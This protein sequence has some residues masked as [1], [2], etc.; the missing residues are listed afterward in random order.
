MSDYP[1][2]TEMGIQN[3]QQIV[4]Y[5]INSM[6]RIDTLR[7]TYKREKGSL[8]PTS[9]SF[10]FPRIQ[11]TPEPDKIA[12]TVLATSP[13]LKEIRRELESLLKLREKTDCTVKTVKKQI[14]ALEN[15]FDMRL[16]EIR[17]MLDE[18]NDAT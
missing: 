5:A 10:E 14:E 9:K 15:E 8:L 11:Q 12:G 1:R 3:P 17:R 2:L 7:I 16:G 18:L 4:S 13:R 6:N